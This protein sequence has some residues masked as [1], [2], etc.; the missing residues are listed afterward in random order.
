MQDDS[1]DEVEIFQRPSSYGQLVV[2]DADKD[3]D[4]SLTSSD[5]NDRWSWKTM[6]DS[7]LYLIIS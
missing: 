4:E 3:L 7:E 6:P 5:L 1:D 2:E